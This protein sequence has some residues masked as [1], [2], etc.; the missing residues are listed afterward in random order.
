MIESRHIS[1][2]RVLL[3]DDAPEFQIDLVNRLTKHQF[4]VRTAS[5]YDEAFQ[6][7][8]K[9]R[10][11]VALIDVCLD[12]ADPANRSGVTLMEE[13][14]RIDPSASVI[15]MDTHLDPYFMRKILRPA[16]DEG[17]VYEVRHALASQYIEKTP[18]D[19]DLLPDMVK[20]VIEDDLH[21]NFDLKIVDHDRI[22][23]TIVSQIV[24]PEP[25]PDARELAA[26]LTELLFKLF[27]KWQR[28]DLQPVSAM[29]RGFSKAFV[30]QAVPYDADGQGAKVI[31]KLGAH[32]LIGEEVSRYQL[33]IQHKTQNQLYPTA[34]MPVCRT[35][36]LGGI[37]YTFAGLTDHVR[38]F[39]EFFSSTD[40]HEVIVSAIKRIFSGTLRLQLTGT[41]KVRH[42]KDL[43]EIY[44]TMLRLRDDEL[45][46]QFSELLDRLGALRLP[47]R[48]E[49]FWLRD[50]TQMVNPLHFAQN[51]SFKMSY[52]EATIHG[53]FHSHN[54]L[55][56]GNGTGWL[57][58]FA[59]TCKGPRF[60][61]FVAL[62][63]SLM[64]E[65]NPIQDIDLL[66][67]WTQ[68]LF[69]QL[70]DL[71][72]PLPDNLA[73]PPELA[74]IHAAMMAI[75]AEAVGYMTNPEVDERAYLV[76]LF[77]TAMRMMTVKF[78]PDGR[79]FH[80]LAVASRVAENLLALERQ[81]A[82]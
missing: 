53:D 30:F 39:A 31:V 15:M 40:D 45:S 17:T 79:R 35:K 42:E 51:T 5:T 3:V 28:V 60:H 4:R 32:G 13:L 81:G 29:R 52:S 33:H 74:K 9:E 37:I 19:L 43:S 22:M 34:I 38:D 44:H 25:R 58:D 24:L 8:S 36:L 46:T 6:I 49:F 82:A 50:G 66:L 75:R 48:P 64:F 47:T 27:Y 10:I 59:D 57:I 61:D 7:V 1:Q 72:P 14:R 62:E 16:R 73:L 2:Y 12:Q 41:H 71:K 11:H 18:A 78:L 54:I 68:A 56:D 20:E 65:N 70:G 76:G 26:E 77:F 69:A 55:L 21:I 63:A 23:R 67:R 80:A